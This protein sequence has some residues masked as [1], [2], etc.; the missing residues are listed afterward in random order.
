[1]T[2]RNDI[3]PDDILV[4]QEETHEEGSQDLSVPEHE[5][6]LQLLVLPIYGRPFMPSQ[7][8]PVQLDS[9]WDDTLREVLNTPH[10]L[11][12]IVTLPE[13]SLEDEIDLKACEKMGTLVRVIQARISDEIQFVAQ[14]LCRVKVDSV[15]RYRNIL[16]AQVSYPISLVPPSDSPQGIEIKA[17]AMSL[18]S[19][20]K[21]LLPLNP[22]Y[23]EELKQYLTRFSPN[24]P[25]LLADCAAA[26]TTCDAKDLQEVLDTVDLLKRLQLSLKLLKNEIQIA[27]LHKKIK[28]EVSQTLSD[29]QREFFLKEQLKEIQ[30]ELGITSDGRTKDIEKF[31]EKIA[32]LDP[33]KHVKERFDEQMARLAV[34]EP[35]SADYGDTRDYLTWITDVPWGHYEHHDINI[36]DARTILDEEHEGLK[37]VK[38]RI[39]EFL[40]VGIYK[41]DINGSI[42]LL[43]G[44]P[45]VGKTSIGKS[46]AKALGRPFYRFS[47]GGMRDEAEI[48]G[49]RRT[50]ISALPGK[51][52]MALKETK[53]M[54]PVIMLDEIDKIT[55]GGVQGDPA[56]ALLETLDPEQ[57]NSFLDHYLDLRVD[58]SKCLFICTANSLDGIPAP[59]LDR[60]DKISLSGYLSQEK[61]DIA[62][63]HVIPKELKKA[64]ANKKQIKFTDNAIKKIIEEYARDAGIRSLE[65]CIA[66]IVRKLVVKLLESKQSY[67][68]KV[69]ELKETLKDKPEEFEAESKKLAP[70]ISSFS[71]KPT[72]IKGYL[73]VA[74]FSREKTLEGVGI[75][76]G[77]A[78]TSMGGATL[79]IEATLVGN[80]EK[81]FKLTGNLGQVMKESAEIALSYVTAHL[82]ELAPKANQ[83]FFTKAL[84]HLHVPEGATPKDG[85]SAGVTMSSALLSLAM[86]KAPK[87]GYAMTGEISLTGSV[88]AIGGIREKVIAAK[89]VGI[90]KLIVPLANKEDVEELPDYVRE[91]VEFNYADTYPDVAKILFD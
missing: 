31:N 17:Y 11:V 61:F 39:I 12:A 24:D 38:E 74:P 16:K 32:K 44:P 41:G 79:P 49:H 50:Y 69:K 63:H 1:M 10:K 22:L 35:A 25:S 4:S 27:N 36:N 7:V 30:K 81:G 83:D 23:F 91:G 48:K 20:I 6:P 76:T 90:N 75:I 5:R 2:D 82:K 37:D 65:K 88:L 13:E 55:Q 8:I 40:S 87:K 29:R 53:V 84:I 56:S 14:G 59:L 28:D 66:K 70:E 45:G 71:V 42:I 72:D 89:R 54:N 77:L 26:I 78:W 73:G 15:K 86:G 51:L 3:E 67:E 9:K 19:T 47:V 21:E 18:V 34:L 52:V 43:V 80:T 68:A 33:P 62:K 46:V 60:M 57:N 58:L 64:G 85:P